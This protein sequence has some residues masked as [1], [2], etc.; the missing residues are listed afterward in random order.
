[1]LAFRSSLILL[2]TL[3]ACGDSGVPAESGGGPDASSGGMDAVAHGDAEGARDGGDAEA[4]SGGEGDGESG[5]PA[6]SWVSDP[7]SLVNTLIGTTAGGNMFP[8]ADVPFGM[9]QWSPDT[10]P[11]RSPGGGYEYNDTQISGFSLTHLDGPGCGAMGDLPILPMTGGLPTGDPGAHTEPFSHTGEVGTAGYYSV[12]SG[13]PS[14]TT[15]LTATL[16]SAMARITFPATSNANVLIKLL[17]SQNGDVGSS[18]TVVGTNEVQGSTRSGF[19]CKRPTDPQYTLYFDIAF[20]QPFVASKIVTPTGGT[21]PGEVFL[22]FDTTTTQVVQAKV[23]ISFVSAANAKANWNAENAA[24]TWNF[25][26]IENAAKASW[27]ALLGQI[28]V[29]GGTAQENELFYT[30]LYH[31]L[32]HPNVFSDTTGQYMGFDNKVHSVSAGQKDQYA[33]YS[34]WDIYHSQVQLSALVAP[35]QM[36]DSAQSMLNDAAQ[37]GGMLPK[38]SMANGETYDMVGDPADGILAGYYAFGARAFDT[39][40]A[41]KVMLAEATTPNNIRPGLSYYTSIGYLPDDGT[42]GCCHYYGSVATLLEYCQAD[43]ALSQF[44]AAMGDTTNANMLLA[45]SQSWQN[46]FDPTTKLFTAR[47]LDGSFVR[48]AGLTTMQGMVEGSASQY[49]WSL[50]YDR[51]AQMAAM[52]GPTAV[53]PMLDAFFAS[54][55]DMSGK[56]AL[57][58]NE[59]EIGAQY[60][61]N[62]TGQPWKTQDIVNRLRTQVYTDT[63]SFVNNNDDLGA[64]SSQL[65]WSMMGLFPAYPGSATLTINGPEFTDLLVHL[66]SGKALTVHADGA[67][68][69]NPYIQS[70]LLDSQPTTQLWLDPK[71]LDTGVRLDFAMGATP[72]TTLGTAASDA[73]PSY[74]MSETSAVGFAA[75][76]PLVVAPGATIA[77]SVGAQSTRDDVPESMTWAATSTGAL[78]VNPASGMLSLTAGAQATQP[79]SIVAPGTQGSYAMTLSLTP[80][81]GPAPPTFVLPVVVAPAGT[82]WPY[83]D[84]VGVSDDTK[85]GAGNLDGAKSSYSAQALAAAGI[86]PGGTVKVGNLSYVWPTQAPGTNDSIWVTGQTVTLGGTAPKTTLGLLGSA[87]SAGSG[88]AQGTLTVHYADKST[89]SVPFTFSDWTL[90]GGASAVAP[91][92][93]VA[94]KCAYHNAAAGKNTTASYV[95][96]FAAPLTSSQPVTSIELPQTTSGGDV[97]VFAIVLM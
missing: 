52:G 65:V 89:Q 39:A 83:F 86:T 80:A 60:W 69:T 4:S 37:N 15:E 67:S 27:N 78:K 12:R 40:T 25:D 62:Y 49:R 85:P 82:I 81:T 75:P 42:Y 90:N 35:Q 61:D 20:D 19:F 96:S 6:V 18:A 57:L 46:V 64:L 1:M 10:S 77:V 17:G 87:T 13:S 94:A 71:V 41:L 73:P 95:F 51:R 53:N 56:G 3:V 32:L 34:G 45:R 38:W 47:L 63:P 91:G 31:S 43:F 22:T 70:L 14:I 55:D 44:A 72:N 66:P 58:T 7:A 16:H 59:F 68:A 23:G 97:H 29:A 11:D 84:D 48:G 79:V 50:G 76:S 24:G 36:S 88:G 5:A 33:N 28:Q 21:Y 74:G 30:S 26:G 93:T 8:G 9:I 92:D 54:L 2:A